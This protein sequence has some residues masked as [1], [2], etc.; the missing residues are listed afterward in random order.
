M[1]LSYLSDLADTDELFLQEENNRYEK[2]VGGWSAYAL[3]GMKTF[4][5]TAE[6][7]IADRSFNEFDSNANQ[8]WAANLEVAW[9]PKPSYQFAVRIEASHEL[10]DQPQRQYG[11]SAA[12]RIGQHIGLA[13]DF[14]YGTFKNNFVLD[15]N[16]NEIDSRVYRM[17]KRRTYFR[18]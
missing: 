6:T 5:I 10:I 13:A 12:W 4:E 14:L 7:V 8:P 11:V 18:T 9:F 1:S 17:A 16:D 2:R 15:D 3:I